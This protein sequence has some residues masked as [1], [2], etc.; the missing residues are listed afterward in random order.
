MGPGRILAG[1]G[2][3]SSTAGT[4]RPCGPTA[5]SGAARLTAPGQIPAGQARLRWQGPRCPRREWGGG[6]PADP[7][8][9]ADV[10]AWGRSSR[11]LRCAPASFGGNVRDHF[12]GGRPGG[13]ALSTNAYAEPTWFTGSDG[14]SQSVRHRWP[15]VGPGRPCCI[16]VGERLAVGEVYG[17]WVRPSPPPIVREASAASSWCIGHGASPTVPLEAGGLGEGDPDWGDWH[18]RSGGGR[19]DGL[20]GRLNRVARGRAT[21]PDRDPGR[22]GRRPGLLGELERLGATG[23]LPLGTKGLAA[24]LAEEVKGP[25][26]WPPF[27]NTRMDGFA[28]RAEDGPGMAGRPAAPGSRR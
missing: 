10:A 28:L 1:R 9:T 24:L 11:E 21:G 8:P 3:W 23:R 22:G 20:A 18:P 17:W 2:R 16:R 15:E 27:A 5:D 14:S 4:E 13:G 26:T 6:G 25:R 12:R 19:P 7:L